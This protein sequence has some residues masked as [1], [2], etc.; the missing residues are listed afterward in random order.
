MATDPPVR[1][2][3]VRLPG[4]PAPSDS[5]DDGVPPGWD[6]NPATWGQRLPIVG[7]A[8]V[9]V[10]IAT[11]LTLFQLGVIS[12]IWEPFFGD[13]SRKVLE[14]KLSRVLPVPDAALG[15]AGY[16]VDAVAG[17][18]GGTR[19]WRTM[20]WIVVVFGLAVGPIGAVSIALVMSQP[21]V[22]GAWCTLCLASAVI[23]LLMIGP[24]MDE[25]LASLQYMK[26]VKEDGR[27][28]WRHF[29]GLADSQ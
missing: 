12:T 8:V 14:S 22:V 3:G 18:I 27:P 21:L 6:Y 25:M 11:W 29:W 17:V 13:G 2:I 4:E 15:A 19:R 16:F 24:A 5:D 23:S 26:R 9:G 20:P 1:S 10:G 28:F 7:L